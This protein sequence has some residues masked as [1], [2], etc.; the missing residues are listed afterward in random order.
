MLCLE[1]TFTQIVKAV[2]FFR[3][4]LPSSLSFHV[5]MLFG[6]H[7]HTDYNCGV[8]RGQSAFVVNFL[9]WMLC[10]ELTFT[11]ITC[12]CVVLQGPSPH[13]STFHVWMLCLELTF[14][15]IVTVDSSGSVCPPH[16]SSKC[17]LE[18]TFTQIVTVE[19]FR[20]SLPSSCLV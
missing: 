11:Q 15:Q 5:W 9:V 10:L 1:L 6:I 19:F 12:N 4:S 17:C 8:L 13:V 2:E 18:L 3:V 7:I 20:V 14:T 16:V